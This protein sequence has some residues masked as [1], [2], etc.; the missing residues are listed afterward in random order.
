MTS[1][2]SIIG[3]VICTGLTILI[4]V[5]LTQLAENK[6]MV[7]KTRIH[8]AELFSKVAN[9]EI[10][11][12]IGFL[13]FVTLLCLWLFPTATAG[14]I[15]EQYFVVLGLGGCIPI[16]L[17]CLILL[18]KNRVSGAGIVYVCFVAIMLYLVFLLNAAGVSVYGNC[19]VL[20]VLAFLCLIA[21]ASR[22]VYKKA[23]N[24]VTCEVYVEGREE[25][26][27]GTDEPQV[28]KNFMRI[29]SQEELGNQV[30][31]DIPLKDVKRTKMI[32]IDIDEND[33]RDNMQNDT[34]EKKRAKK[35]D[36]VAFINMCNQLKNKSRGSK[37]NDN[38]ASEYELAK[39][40]VAEYIRN[41][42]NKLLQLKAEARR[43]NFFDYQAYNI[44]VIALVI[45]CHTLLFTIIE[46]LLSEFLSLYGIGILVILIIAAIFVYYFE[47]RYKNIR[48]WGPYIQVAIEDFEQ[49]HTEHKELDYKSTVEEW[50]KKDKENTDKK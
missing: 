20:W 30:I 5:V 28:R 2:M 36:K 47:V 15:K 41:N 4:P 10:I 1:I 14:N 3:D 38:P 33:L 40:E 46:K 22:I 35:K 21:Q 23:A 12:S 31:I 45:G 37:N 6:R 7:K 24:D 26:Y 42:E 34:G 18:G 49:Y 32:S 9:G 17:Y 25:P 48:K 16:V 27:I 13:F 29:T 43:E 19:I 50:E 8:N 44:S 11:I 39:V